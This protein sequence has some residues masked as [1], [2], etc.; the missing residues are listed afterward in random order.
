MKRTSKRRLAAGLGVLLCLLAGIGVLS[1][2]KPTFVTTHGV[3]MQPRF[4]TGD[5]AVLLP[6]NSYRVGDIA[7]YHSTSLHT[8]VMHRIVK[9]AD[10]RY[11][12]KGDNNSWLDQ[13]PVTRSQLVGKLALRVP[14]GGVIMQKAAKFAPFVLG[15]AVLLFGAGLASTQQAGRRKP[16]LPRGRKGAAGDSRR[17]R[18]DA[19]AG[20]AATAAA[21]VFGVILAVMALVAPAATAAETTPSTEAAARTVFSYSAHVGHT[22][23]YDQTTATAPA[24]IF[25]KITNLVD[26]SAAYT[27]PTGI[28][29]LTADLSTQAGWHST[30]TLCP[31]TTVTGAGITRTVHLDLRAIDARAQAAAAATGTTATLVKIDILATVTSASGAPFASVLHLTMS[32]LELSMTGSAKALAHQSPAATNPTVSA[33]R[34]R[35][36]NLFGLH[37]PAVV[38]LGI[39]AAILAICGLS[40]GGAALRAR[41]IDKRGESEAIRRRYQALLVPTEPVSLPPGGPLVDV[42]DMATLAK[43]AERY[44]LFV[45]HWSRAGVETYVVQD[46]STTYRYRPARGASR[47]SP[48]PAVQPPAPPSASPAPLSDQLIPP[49]EPPAPPPVC[50][51]AERIDLDSG[52]L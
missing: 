36:V 26:L 42:A 50:A 48:G 23:A 12:F 45:L 3:S 49:S 6:A 33:H 16:R 8:V 46:D 14:H 10:G 43:I 31:A 40:A 4:H 34:P 20:L 5:L 24:P 18:P 25:R 52:I 32:P 39:A 1:V 27:G 17:V 15:G 13:D 22:A 47:P 19:A 2:G 21:A 9:I 30:M 28:F 51:G 44:G 41:A 37:I 7:A 29:T 35:T 11:T 38:A